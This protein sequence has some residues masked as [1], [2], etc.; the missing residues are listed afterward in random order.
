MWALIQA[1]WLAGS[2]SPSEELEFD[3]RRVVVAMLI[4]ATLLLVILAVAALI[5][6]A[7]G[8]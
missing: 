1:L 4:G 2:R 8:S 7:L 5:V 3:R 6:G